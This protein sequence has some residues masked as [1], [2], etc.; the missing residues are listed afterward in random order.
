MT[1]ETLDSSVTYTGNGIA[2]DWVFT[3]QVQSAEDISVSISGLPIEEFSVLVNPDGIGG[4]VRTFDPVPD[5]E[6]IRIFRETEETQGVD[7]PE[8]GPFPARNNEDALDK[9]TLIVQEV[10]RDGGLTEEETEVLRALFVIIDERTT[11]NAAD[12]VINANAI[13]VNDG[14][15]TINLNNIAINAADISA[16]EFVQGDYIQRTGDQ[17]TGQ[18]GVFLAPFDDLDA[19]S[20]IFLRNFTAALIEGLVLL[21][22]YDASLGTP[23]DRDETGEFFIIAIAGV[24][25]VSNGIDPAVPTLVNQ[26]DYIIWVDDP[27]NFWVHIPRLIASAAGVSFDAAGTTYTTAN[28]QDALAEADNEMF[29]HKRGTILD[30]IGGTKQFTTALLIGQLAPQL[31]RID[32]FNQNQISF[33]TAGSNEFNTAGTVRFIMNTLDVWQLQRRNDAGTAWVVLFDI[34]NDNDEAPIFLT[35]IRGSQPPV[36]DDDLTRKDYV[37]G[38]DLSNVKLTGDQDIEGDKTFKSTTIFGV[39]DAD[40][41]ITTRLVNILG[42]FRSGITATDPVFVFDFVNSAGGFQHGIYQYNPASRVF[43]FDEDAFPRWVGVPVLPQDLVNVLYVNDNF[44]SVADLANF[45][46]LS[47]G[48][49][50]GPVSYNVSSNVEFLAFTMHQNQVQQVFNVTGDPALGTNGQMK[51]EMQGDNTWSMQTR[52][53]GSWA[54]I[55]NVVPGS[56]KANFVFA[57]TAALP[58]TGADLT[59]RNY[60]DDKT[61]HHATVALAQAASVGDTNNIHF[62]DEG[63]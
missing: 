32:I 21:G 35:G 56:Q 55:F 41:F 53:T 47:G 20:N 16:L 24:I 29:V 3:Y 50:T 1:V 46:P 4:Q 33:L 8:Y 62:A 7:F 23:A 37:D 34:P 61:E 15:I 36:A 19:V 42:G 60:V 12:I 26:G 57:P 2:V 38:L 52:I 63:S 18:L 31:S 44:V 51:F 13:S 43:S 54:T 14:R 45:M 25:D 48:T 6:D 17:M 59:N 5:G 40:S 11:Q 27:D 39:D 49:F 58:V 9:L 28:V 10:A 22:F 30:V